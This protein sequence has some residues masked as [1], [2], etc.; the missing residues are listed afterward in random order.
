VYS[1]PLSDFYTRYVVPNLPSPESVAAFHMGLL[2][3]VAD[4]DPLLLVRYMSGTKRGEVYRTADGSRFKATDNAPAWR[5]H[6]LLLC[7]GGASFTDFAAAIGSMPAHM[8][9]VPARPHTANA[10]G[11][12]IAHI[13]NVKD[14]N[15]AWDSWPRREVIRRFVLNVHPCNYFLLAKEDWTEWGEVDAVKNYIAGKFSERYSPTWKEFRELAETPPV[16]VGVENGQVT[17]HYG[18]PDFPNRVDGS[19]ERD[20]PAPVTCAVRYTASR[21]LFRAAV[22]E[23]LRDDES[24][25]VE[26]PAGAFKMTKAEFYREFRNVVRSRSYTERGIYH[27]PS[28]PRKALQFAMDRGDGRHSSDPG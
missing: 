7:Y 27:Y 23:P 1:G 14:R 12:H 5:I 16:A 26:T 15:T 4:P 11:W 20:P 10:L 13:V 28:I 21:L 2:G 8:F 18:S 9:D 17:Y 19:E 3:Y 25:C 22:I 24:F 6:A